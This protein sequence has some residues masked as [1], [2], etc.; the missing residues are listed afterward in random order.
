MQ[1]DIAHKQLP[2]SKTDGTGASHSN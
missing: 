2:V 1:K